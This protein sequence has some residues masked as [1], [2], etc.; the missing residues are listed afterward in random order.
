MRA[1]RDLMRPLT[2][3]AQT[4]LAHRY[5]RKDERGIVVETP[6]EMFA[7]VARAVARAEAELGGDAAAWEA[8]FLARLLALEF[9]PNSPTL[10][11]AGLDHGQLS[12]CFVLPV[13]DSLDSI[14]DTVKQAARIHQ[15]GGGTGFAFSH[16]RPKGDA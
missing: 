10:M 16:L 1:D 3:S 12:A 11:N 6:A 9:L 8:R 2:P 4:V 13:E 7:R 5:L 14:F 15:T